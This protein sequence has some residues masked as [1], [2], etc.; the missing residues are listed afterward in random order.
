PPCQASLFR[1]SLVTALNRPAV[2]TSARVQTLTVA[3]GRLL[4]A[5]VRVVVVVGECAAA[6]WTFTLWCLWLHLIEGV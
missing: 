6:S 5:H 2:V 1:P 3:R 4:Y